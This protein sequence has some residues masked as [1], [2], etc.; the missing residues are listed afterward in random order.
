MFCILALINQTKNFEIKA[1]ITYVQS[2]DNEQEFD[3]W[4]KKFDS[5]LKNIYTNKN[6][7]K[8]PNHF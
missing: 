7:Y 3:V 5:R 4:F 1:N 6:N 8:L 2:Y